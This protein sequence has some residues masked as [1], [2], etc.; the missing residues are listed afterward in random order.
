MSKKTP[1]T[2]SSD[3]MLEWR[4]VSDRQIMSKWYILIYVFTCDTWAKL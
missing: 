4:Y 3:A 1:R 2:L